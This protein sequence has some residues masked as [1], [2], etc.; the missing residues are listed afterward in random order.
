ML[1]K[2]RGIVIKNIT[3]GETSL[4]SKILLQNEGL[5]TFLVNGVRSKKSKFKPAYFQLFTLLELDYYQKES[6]NFLRI[7][8]IKPDPLLHGLQANVKKILLIQRMVEF[9][10][11]ILLD[12]LSEPKSFDW[13]K[14][15]ILYVNDHEVH[16][17]ALYL[18][19]LIK[20]GEILGIS[21]ENLPED[22]NS[23]DLEFLETS[24]NK[25]GQF[26]LSQEDKQF[27][28]VVFQ[29][30]L[31]E[32]QKIQ[33]YKGIKRLT[34]TLEKFYTHK[35]RFTVHSKIASSINKLNAP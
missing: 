6:T 31:A 16:P 35:N 8:E 29:L 10:N 24:N 22:Q 1:V 12:N 28:R 5:K 20:S 18:H 34:N 26:L 7:K 11:N 25:N 19:F 9:I 3:Y 30:K 13:L 21:L 14:K 4:I 2:G 15:Y 27:V 23:F 17:P 33:R 32:H